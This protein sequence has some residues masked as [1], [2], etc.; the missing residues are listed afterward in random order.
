MINS[1]LIKKDIYTTVC[2]LS[3]GKS[4][5]IVDIEADDTLKQRLLNMGLT[6]GTTI[7]FVRTAPLGDPIN[8]KVRGFNLGIRKET[9]KRIIIK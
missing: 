7:H 3:P 5:E 6:P 8:V 1:E 4:G 2:D 9:A